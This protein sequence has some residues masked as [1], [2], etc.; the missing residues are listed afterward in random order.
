MA[1]KTGT[2]G[3]KAPPVKSGES[4]LMLGLLS[5]AALAA[6]A[7]IGVAFIA[8]FFNWLR[9]QNHWSWNKSEDWGHA[10]VVPLVSAF[11]IWRR[12]EDIR[13]TVVRPFWPGL[14]PLMLGL[15]CFTFFLIYVPNH[16]LQGL[17]MLLTLAG[18]ALTVLGPAAFRWV[19]LP[20]GFLVLAITISEMIMIRITFQ[21]QLIASAGAEIVLEVLAIFLGFD[22]TRDGNILSIVTDGETHQMNVAEACSGMR[23][24]IAFLALASAV[25]VLGSRRWWK[26]L[27]LIQLSLPVALLMNVIRVSVLGLLMLVDPSLAEGDAHTTIGT[28]LLIPSLALFMLVIWVLNKIAPEESIRPQKNAAQKASP[29]RHAGT[30]NWVSAAVMVTILIGGAAIGTRSLVSAMGIHLRKLP[31]EAP[32]PLR[33]MAQDT[34]MW[35]SASGDTIVERAET[36]ETLGTTNYVTRRVVRRAPLPEVSASS[37]LM[38]AAYYTGSIDTVPHVPERCF[39]GG[40]LQIG[41]NPVVLPIDLRAGEPGSRLQLERD[42]IFLSAEQ[43]TPEELRPVAL[44]N[45]ERGVY[46]FELGSGGGFVRAPFDP[47]KLRMRITT[48][49]DNEGNAEYAGYFFIANG[50]LA[51]SAEN[52]RLLAFDKRAKYA[53]YLKV[54]FSSGEVGS[55]EELATLA[56]DY[57]RENLGELLLCKPDWIDVRARLLA[58]EEPVTSARSGG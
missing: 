37:L 33:E 15:V 16:M 31:L 27:M 21:L 36:L 22:V 34:G 51:A 2:A 5:P 6:C 43:R 26:R 24:V 53:Y 7:A 19:V 4:S 8:L 14:L 12:R 42:N 9:H 20:I 47:S 52:V 41:K 17:S 13:A 10:Y 48:F 46:W 49:F 30:R 44:E 39:V 29:V 18:A 38:H 57:L 50:G 3:R 1:E 23:M 35:F 45:G 55:P 40:G 54:Q 11:M 25:A 56:A 28:I 32:R 58:G